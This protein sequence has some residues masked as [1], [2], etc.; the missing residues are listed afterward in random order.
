MSVWHPLWLP[1][2]IIDAAEEQEVLMTTRETSQSSNSHSY[3]GSSDLTV[4]YPDL[5]V[6]R[7]DDP[8]R[9][10]DGL[11][12]VSSAKW[13]EFLGVIEGCDHWEVR[14]ARGLGADWDEGWGRMWKEWIGKLNSG[15]NN[16][17]NKGDVWSVLGKAKEKEAI[18][19]MEPLKR[20]GAQRKVENMDWATRNGL[21]SK[22]DLERFYVAISRKLYDEGL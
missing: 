16:G 19:K 6:G 2:L 3:S 1:K 4:S 18:E 21:T 8:E 7:E 13:G 5:N 12:T 17:S 9:G 10:N 20:D 14:G 22:F 15:S 11:V